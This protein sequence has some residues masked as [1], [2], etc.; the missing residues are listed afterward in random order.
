MAL[1]DFSDRAAIANTTAN[2]VKTGVTG[3]TLIKAGQLVVL[4]DT[5]DDTDL[6]AKVEVGINTAS[7]GRVN[8][9][10]GSLNPGAY[11]FNDNDIILEGAND[12]LEIQSDTADVFTYEIAGFDDFL[13]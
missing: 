1:A 8:L 4:N 2:S 5:L 6:T 11:W 13:S 10:N 9:F 3:G 12:V 7:G